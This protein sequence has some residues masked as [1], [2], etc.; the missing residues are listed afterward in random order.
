MTLSDATEKASNLHYMHWI[1]SKLKGE[2]GLNSV[3][4]ARA[5][6]NYFDMSL[7][8]RRDFLKAPSTFHL[9]K[10]IIL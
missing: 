10:T 1:L 2:H 8:E 6:A 9:C 5:P 4:I 3:Q 7:E